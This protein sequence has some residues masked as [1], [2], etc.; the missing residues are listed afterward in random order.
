MTWETRFV[1]QAAATCYVFIY[2]GL[3]HAF[4]VDG[5]RSGMSLTQFQREVTAKGAESWESNGNYFVGRK[6]EAR[7][8]G[9]FYFCQGR[10]VSYSRS[11]D[12]DVDFSSALSKLLDQLGRPDRIEVLQQNWTGPGSGLINSTYMTWLHSDEKLILSFT[13]EGRDGK[14]NLRYNRGASQGFQIRNSCFTSW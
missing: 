9:S 12:F 11:I 13:P 10:L 1:V 4:D 6:G 8:D 3:G 14:G 2:A 5:W 7:I